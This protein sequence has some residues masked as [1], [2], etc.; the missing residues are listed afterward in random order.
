MIFLYLNQ[1]K[2]LREAGARLGRSHTTIGREIKR[3]GVYLDDIVKPN[4][5]PSQAEDF[6]KR[7]RLDSKKGKLDDPAIQRYVLSKLT[8]GWSPEQI[9]GRLKLVALECFV[10]HETIYK[11]IYSKENRKLRFWE[12]L[13]RGRRIRQGLF[14]RKV[15][16]RRRLAIPRKIPI[17]QR[18]KEAN[19]RIEVGHLETDNMEGSRFSKDAVSVSADRRSLMVFLDKLPN[20]ESKEK[21]MAL[22]S[23]LDRLPFALR[24]TMTFDN[25]SENY[26]HFELRENYGIKTY[27]CNPYHSWEKGTVENTIGIVRQYF[28]KG[29]DLSKVT[30]EELNIVERELNNRPR[31]KLGFYTPAEFVYKEI[32]WCT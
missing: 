10:S 24:K 14:S 21:N 11:F 26:H 29:M 13:R 12:F 28:P 15:Q 4:Y 27:F 5:L 9:A 31:K 32:K 30:Q 3:N 6:S 23:R 20:K 19:E 2:S 18:P 25:G 22:S 8:K 17:E 16:T 7:K 1:G